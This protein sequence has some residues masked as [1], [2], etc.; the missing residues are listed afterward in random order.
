MEQ[1][2]EAVSAERSSERTGD[3]TSAV[4][5]GPRERVFFDQTFTHIVAGMTEKLTPCRARIARD[6][7]F[8]FRS[9]PR[10]PSP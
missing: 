2:R 7:A 4:M 9:S 6:Y 5:R 10:H 8:K 3:R 1:A